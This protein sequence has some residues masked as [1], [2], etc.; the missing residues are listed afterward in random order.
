MFFNRKFNQSENGQALIVVSFL[1]VFA[2]SVGIAI[3]NRLVVGLRRSSDV[4]SSDRAVA[5]AEALVENILLIDD[6]TLTDYAVNGTCTTDCEH[7][8]TDVLGQSAT[9]TAEV[10]ILGQDSQMDLRLAEGES[11]DVLLSGMPSDL[12]YTVCWD[13][14]G[15]NYPSVLAYYVSSSSGVYEM[16]A[17]AYNTIGSSQN[18]GFDTPAPDYGY[19][20]CFAVSGDNT[21]ELLRLRAVYDNVSVNIQASDSENFPMQGVEIIATGEFAELTRKVRVTKSG[22]SLPTEFEYVMFTKSDSEP[23]AN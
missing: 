18:N 7:T 21:P 17:Y 19:S 22:I 11:M 20:N 16:E 10:S 14:A 4:Q 12:T 3:A 6:S 23:L 5:V 2:L 9:A 1:V 13:D 15:S 8:L